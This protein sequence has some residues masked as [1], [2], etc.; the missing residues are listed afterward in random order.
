MFEQK[1]VNCSNHNAEP[2][3]WLCLHPAIVVQARDIKEN[4]LGLLT[5]QWGAG[6][7]GWAI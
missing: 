7:C 1:P 2:S 5:P 3:L 4:I 6:I